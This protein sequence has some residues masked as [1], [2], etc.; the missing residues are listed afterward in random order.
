MQSPEERYSESSVITEEEKT[1][2]VPKN[3]CYSLTVSF[4]DV[5]DLIKGLPL[6][7]EG[8]VSP[9]TQHFKSSYK[10]VN[11]DFFKEDGAGLE[12][13]QLTG[14]ADHKKKQRKLL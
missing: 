4:R 5:P 9:H 8:L 12:I 10:T 1:V 13:E 2:Y 6:E 14:G 7:I 11:F 3:N